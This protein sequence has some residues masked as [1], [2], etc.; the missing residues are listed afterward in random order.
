MRS[1]SEQCYEA[2]Q[3]RTPCPYCGR[4]LRPCNTGPHIR[5]AHFRQLT[6]WDML[7][8]TFGEPQ[9]PS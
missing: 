3:V 2:A 8:A 5:A 9:R 4:H 1:I 6:I 7:K